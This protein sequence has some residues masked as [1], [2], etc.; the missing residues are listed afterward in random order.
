M[1]LNSMHYYNNPSMPCS[2][3]RGG[4]FSCRLQTV[5]LR[6]VGE[7]P[8]RQDPVEENEPAEVEAE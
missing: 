4:G 6:S 3:G 5:P 7:N 2:R 8:Q 1:P